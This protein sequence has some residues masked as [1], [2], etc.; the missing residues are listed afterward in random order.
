V[1]AQPVVVPRSVRG[2]ATF[3]AEHARR[4][5]RWYGF[6][7]D[8]LVGEATPAK[9]NIGPATSRAAQPLAPAAAIARVDFARAPGK[10]VRGRGECR[11][12]TEGHCDGIL[13]Y[14]ELDLAPGVTYSNAPCHVQPAS[15]WPGVIW[16]LDQ[17]V[18]ADPGGALGISFV[19]DPSGSRL[20][21]RIGRSAPRSRK[22]AP[23]PAAR[24]STARA[25]RPLPGSGHASGRAPRP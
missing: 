8:A 6:S 5:R 16:L 18:H 9:V 10:D 21:V 11:F 19:H 2:Y 13:V 12:D 22:P 3:T 4:W 17:P 23:R 1:F 24:R 14:F 7:F 25:G 15:S 20:S